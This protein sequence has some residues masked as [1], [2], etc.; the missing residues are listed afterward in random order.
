MV[1]FAECV[2]QGSKCRIRYIG[3]REKLPVMNPQQVKV[4]DITDMDPQPQINWTLQDDGTLVEDTSPLP[5][6]KIPTGDFVQRFTGKQRSEIRQAAKTDDVIDDLMF[7][8]DHKKG[9]LTNLDSPELQAGIHYIA[10]SADVPS[11]TTDD[12]KTVLR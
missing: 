6:G 1:T 5:F 9:E 10:D 7:L 11:F 3:T 12:I 4:V 2:R 8:L